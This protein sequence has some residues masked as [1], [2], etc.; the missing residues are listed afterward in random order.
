MLRKRSRGKKALYEIIGGAR[1]KAGF[2]RALG[3]IQQPSAEADEKQEWIPPKLGSLP[4]KPRMV[5]YNSGRIELSIPYQI[6]IA[7]LLG[8]ILLFLVVYRLGQLS[9]AGS[10]KTTELATEMPKSPKKTAEQPMAVEQRVIEQIKEVVPAPAFSKQFEQ[11][12]D[13]GSNRIVIQTYQLKT[14][15]EPVKQFFAANGIETEIR[16]I[17]GLYY[18]VTSRKYENPER[19]GTDGYNMKQ[20]IIKLGASYKAPPGYETFGRKPFHD[21]YG[22]RFDD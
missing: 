15:L 6:C 22:M 9:N 18:L 1:Y 20:Q 10:Q 19:P 16:E 11:A 4:K 21:A 8:A 7:V 12:E 14:A 5:Q 17:G 13:A 3:Q 2:D